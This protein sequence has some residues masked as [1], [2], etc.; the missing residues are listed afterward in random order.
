LCACATLASANFFIPRE[1]E[2]EF[3]RIVELEDLGVN[4]ISRLI[5]F[6]EKGAMPLNISLYCES[7]SVYIN[8]C[9]E[10]SKYSNSFVYSLGT[11]SLCI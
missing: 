7:R 6:A 4:P 2:P 3:T 1:R 10:R 11:L 9:D 5:K 8:K